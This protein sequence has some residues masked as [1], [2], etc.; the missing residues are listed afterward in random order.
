[1]N[2]PLLSCHLIR[3]YFLGGDRPFWEALNGNFERNITAN[4]VLI[5]VTL[6]VASLL[7]VVSFGFLTSHKCC[8]IIRCMPTRVTTKLQAAIIAELKADRNASYSLIAERV[9]KKLSRSVSPGYV[10]NIARKFGLERAGVTIPSAAVSSLNDLLEATHNVSPEN[11]EGILEDSFALR[12]ARTSE[13]LGI[14]PPADKLADFVIDNHPEVIINTREFEDCM[15]EVVAVLAASDNDMARAVA[16]RVTQ[17]SELLHILAND[18]SAYVRQ[19]V[20]ANFFTSDKDISWLTVDI[21]P[22]VQEFASENPHLTQEMLSVVA[23]SSNVNARQNAA[24][25]VLTYKRD[26]MRLANDERFEVRE[27]VAA[28]ISTPKVCLAKMV[29]DKNVYVRG[30]VAGNSSASP[31]VLS[32]LKSDNSPYVLKCLAGNISTPSDVLVELV[33]KNW[34]DVGV[35]HNVARNVSAPSD[36]VKKL[37]SHHKS[38]VR[39]GVAGNPSADPEVLGSLLY[40]FSW[41]VRRQLANNRSIPQDQR[42]ALKKDIVKEVRDDAKNPGR[43]W[44]QGEVPLPKGLDI[45]QN[46]I[47]AA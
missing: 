9:A 16:A 44:Y 31:G 26:L 40:D 8:A 41:M 37:V 25:N 33:A 1:M 30:G 5:R 12:I 24:Y 28:N 17:N 29:R 14:E 46:F 23:E 15:D 6:T 27:C 35:C 10:G 19:Y 18:E 4:K 45:N 38:A 34:H 21:N 39:E 36:V 32:N 42:A 11:N 3:I 20:A 7:R 2:R 22:E 47:H 43:G 13:A